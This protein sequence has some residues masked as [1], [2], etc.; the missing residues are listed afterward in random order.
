MPFVKGGITAPSGF[1]GAAAHCGIKKAKLDLALIFSE[2]PSQ[3]AG[4]FTVN[5]IVAAPVKLDRKKIKKGK[6]KAII[7]NAGNAN[8]CTGKKGLEDAKE[9]ARFTALALGIKAEEILVS[10]TGI[11][12]KNL[13]M[14]R[15]KIGISSLM[16]RLSKEN[17]QSV[18]EAIM[19]TDSFLK[20]SAWQTTIAGRRI[21]IGGVAKGAGM[22]CPNMATMLC[23]LTTD[24]NI[25]KK[26]L[27]KA[28]REAVDNSF[29]AI[30][31]D[32]DQSTNDMVII[33]ANG[34]AHNKKIEKENKDFLK[35][36]EGLNLVAQ[37]LAGKIVEDGEGATKFIE[38]MVK[39]ASN[40]RE[41]EK[42]ARAIA[43]SNLV[44][45]SFFGADPNWGRIMA[46]LGSSVIKLKEEKIDI[47]Y[48]DRP[49][50]KKGKAFDFSPARIYRLL[51]NRK[52]SILVNLGIGKGEK[53]ILTT[54]LSP[55]YIK[56]N[57]GYFHSV[58]KANT[59]I[60]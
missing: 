55:E 50:V 31:I 5:K 51:K 13:P 26:L 40:G 52:I 6:F 44:K 21:K 9:T 33:L 8:A 41:A 49:V 28:L 17:H 2:V 47:Y 12:G 59:E 60:T 32:G 24:A 42:A 53:K 29:N 58:R 38:I 46:A 14:E 22:I 54:D 27:R 39:G 3:A 4:V 15:L 56:I 36:K 19:T 34:L 18:A 23:F 37:F 43:R 48:G 45:T 11:I 25:S 10:S 20:E 16:H 57:A 1:K 35:F 30:T 7:V